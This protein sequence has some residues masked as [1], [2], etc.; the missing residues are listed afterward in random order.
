MIENNGYGLSTP[1][2]EQYNCKNLSDKG[3]GYGIESMKLDGNNIIEVYSK[4]KE[5]KKK[6]KT[7]TNT[8]SLNI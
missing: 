3:I 6:K 5:K 4:K 2:S 1:V 7:T 8:K